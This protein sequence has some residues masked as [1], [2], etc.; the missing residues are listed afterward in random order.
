MSLIKQVV[1]RFL[2]MFMKIRGISHSE[3]SIKTW[4]M[5]EAGFKMRWN[6][7]A[8]NRVL[9]FSLEENSTMAPLIGIYDRAM[10]SVLM[11]REGGMAFQ[12]G[13]LP[14]PQV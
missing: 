12:K 4:N 1:S 14:A 13:G 5:A 2:G 6:Q 7:R 8:Q 3:S 9:E 10:P 11:H